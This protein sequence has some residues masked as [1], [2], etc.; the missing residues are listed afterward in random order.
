MLKSQRPTIQM[1]AE[2]VAHTRQRIALK[3]F[4][5]YSI[6]IACTI[7]FDTQVYDETYT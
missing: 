3:K 4:A 7:L 1:T 6:A 2:V 5:R